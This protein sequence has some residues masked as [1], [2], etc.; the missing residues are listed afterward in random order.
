MRRIAQCTAV[1]WVATVAL[2]VGQGSVAAENVKVGFA[3]ADVT[4]EVGGKPPVYIAGYGQ[5][6]KATGVHDPLYVR[7]IVLDDGQKRIALAVVDVVGLQYPTVQEIRSRI[8][9]FDY[10]LVASTHNHE[11]PDVVGIWGPTPFQ[12]GVNPQYMETVIA[13]TVETIQAADAAKSAVSGAYGTAVDETLLRDSREPYV[14]DGVLRVVRFD[15]A[16]TKKPRTLLVNWTCHPE[17]LASENQQITADFPHYVIRDLEA[18]YGC[19]VIYFSGAVGGLM[20]PP[21]DLYK[22]ADGTPLN[23]GS[24]E[25]CERYGSDVAKLAMQA[26]DAAEPTSL[27]PLRV[28][29][30]PITVPLQNKL[31]RAAQM[32]GVLKREGLQWT[33]NP[34]ERGEPIK[35]ANTKDVAA[36]VTEVGY[37]GVGDIHIAAIPGEVYPESVYG[38]VQEPADPSA[39]FPEAPAE[40]S[41]VEILPG[42]KMLLFGLANDELGYILPKRQ[43]DEKAPF[44]YGREKDQYGE[45]NSC[46]PLMAPL[47]YETLRR[48]V[49]EATQ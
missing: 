27:A 4:P 13:K 8:S 33:G 23:D 46:G 5:N 24:F 11:G 49:Q 37:V 28:A 43:W 36:G 34:E 21:R 15:D 16:Q 26:I 40:P 47:L 25:Y 2:V 6:R 22:Q 42:K 30:K 48:R 10:V 14:K 29:A 7:A 3:K 19:P 20:A 44:A 39:D 17:A 35:P 18:K 1:L 31:Y 38:K 41:I 32:M 12:S 45:G 9:G